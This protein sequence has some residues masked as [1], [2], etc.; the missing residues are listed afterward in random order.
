LPKSDQGTGPVNE[1]QLLNAALGNMPCG[2]S[3]W[4]EQFTLLLFNQRYLEIY[5]LP[6]KEVRRGMALF[7]LHKVSLEAGNHP[8][9]SAEEVDGYFG[10]IF[11]QLDEQGETARF[12]N[13]LGD[14]TIR[15]RMARRRGL[16]WLVTHEDVTED[17]RQRKI[18][19]ENQQR[20]L[21][22][23]IWF[24]RAINS[25]SQGLCAFD[26]DKRLIICNRT[27]AQTYDLPE[28]LT[29]P[30]TRFVDIMEYR[31]SKGLIPQGETA[32]S[33]VANRMALAE[34]QSS[35]QK[36]TEFENGR[37]IYVIKNPMPGGGWIGIVHD[38]TEEKLNEE[39]VRQRSRDLK[40]QN[41]RF[42]AAVDNMAQGLAMFDADKK[43]V[44]CNS[45]YARLYD[46]PEELTKPGALFSDIMDHR[47]SIGM[48][49]A[50]GGK[51]LSKRVGQLVDDSLS[52]HNVCEMQN[53]RFI[54]IVH[55][56]IEDG[57]WVSTHEDITERHL[58]EAHVQHLARHDS[59]TDLPN[60]SYF[61][62]ELKRAEVRI[63]RGEFWAVLCLDLDRFKEVNDTLGHGVGD[64]VLKQV[65]KRLSIATR[66][67]EMVA[68]MGGDE[69]M[70]LA[71]PLHHPRGAALVAQRVQKE[72]DRPM[73]VEG[74]PINMATS[75]GIAIGPVDGMDSV[76]LLRNAD[77]ALYKAKSEGGGGFC[78]F[79]PEMDA[80]A[81]RRRKL[82][83]ELR[84]AHRDNQFSLLYQ[85]MLELESN[86]VSCCE[87]LLRWNHPERGL[88]APEEFMATA[89]ET[90]LI[91]PMGEW[92]LRKACLAAIDWP[93]NVR[94]A[95]NL[96]SVQFCGKK[97]VETVRG[98][99]KATGL[100]PNRLELEITESLLH[101]N[102][103]NTLQSLKEL[104]SMGVR[105][106]LDDFGTGHS[107][108]NY[109]RQFSFDKIKID[110]SFIAELENSPEDL[111]IVRAVIGLAHRL[112]IVAN[113]EGVE[114]ETQ[115]DIVREQGC[116][117]VQ[118]FLFSVPLPENSIKEL[119]SVTETMAASAAGFTNI[120][121]NTG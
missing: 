75:I 68:R 73:E 109:L 37:F 104:R 84:E 31:V 71:G 5:N 67:D 60:R 96:S 64:G 70:I 38:V 97:L 55:Q 79:E 105:I 2:F 113:V 40:L 99:L 110:A 88:L 66:S 108:L 6:A 76:T 53:N 86:R 15:V 90:G 27:Y 33:H 94:V 30:G 51:W 39:L 14:K 80:S 19:K 49:P 116:H 93:Q 57:G 21:T 26:A 9:M 102:T 118:G 12:E 100:E 61:G 77:L 48:V 56:S 10:K 45:H 103:L 119:L 35:E 59:L 47:A 17:V 44:I 54:S 58:N 112:G 46:L 78:F 95:V 8:Q 72:L 121:G 7:D 3:V 92:V 74:H 52:D 69:F 50:A 24:D 85:P 32:K 13:I 65:A 36:F 81:R 28:E 111:E 29:R 83:R 34:S 18:E 98:T 43:L 82:E 106:S 115:L 23:S 87:A 4:S 117:E 42:E 114:T 120:Q 11:S 22:Q 89:E 101:A 107:S 62:E 16:G 91:V 1:A 63:G 41:L 20:V 25:M